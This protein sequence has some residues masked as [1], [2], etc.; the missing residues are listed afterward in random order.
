MDEIHSSIKS[1][2]LDC[3]GGSCHFERFV[4]FYFALSRKENW[5]WKINDKWL[6]KCGMRRV[7]SFVLCYLR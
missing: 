2:R 7:F 6:T 5:S 4:L 3:H 1:Y